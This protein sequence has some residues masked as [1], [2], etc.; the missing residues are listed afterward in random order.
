MSANDAQ[1]NADTSGQAKRAEEVGKHRLVLPSEDPTT[2][3]KVETILHRPLLRWQHLDDVITEFATDSTGQKCRF[4]ANMSPGGG[5][6]VAAAE[7]DAAE[8]A[9]FDFDGFWAHGLPFM[10]EVALEMPTLFRGVDLPLLLDFPKF[11]AE[12][13]QTVTL[14]RRQVASLLAHSVFGSITESARA[15]RKEKWTFRASQLFFLESLPAAFSLLNYFRILGKHG[16]PCGSVMYERL[17]FDKKAGAP[18]TFEANSRSLCRVVF[19]GGENGMSSAT[20]TQTGP[21]PLRMEDSICDLH[22]DFAN[23]FVGGGCLEN[24]KAQE[25]IM[26]AMKPELTVVM[27]LASFLH[28]EEVVRVHGALQFSAYSGFGTSF[29]FEG[30]YDGSGRVGV[31]VV[32]NL[33]CV[34]ENCS[35]RAPLPPTIVAMDA[36]YPAKLVQF[37]NEQIILRDINKARLGFSG[38]SSV[39]TGNWGCGAFGNDHLLKF[40]QQWVAATDAGVSEL[41]Y[42]TYGDKR[43]ATCPSIAAKVRDKTVGELWDY[44]RGAAKGCVGPFAGTTFRENLE[45]LLSVR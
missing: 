32:E 43:A 20:S 11:T 37:S 6:R 4:F 23:R 44:V 25:E 34:A 18:W 16:V 15:V 12:L 7:V 41:H 29:A 17:A 26:F 8:A 30:D 35:G 40:L 21:L 31:G 13:R 27:A 45:T 42:F 28:D 14:T 9:K 36:L 38:F 3:A 33:R 22:V 1:V 5:T 24:D 19:P 39:A 10:V 2:W